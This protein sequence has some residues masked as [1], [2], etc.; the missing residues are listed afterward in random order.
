LIPLFRQVFDFEGSII[1]NIT[2][3][4]YFPV[5][6]IRLMQVPGLHHGHLGL[7]DAF[8]FISKVTDLKLIDSL[9]FDQLVFQVIVFSLEEG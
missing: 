2:H 7:S 1:D 9:S 6:D 3:L 8:K 5:Q 4:F